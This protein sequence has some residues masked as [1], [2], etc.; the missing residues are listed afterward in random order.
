[1]QEKKDT[2]ISYRLA[3]GEWFAYCIYS[4]LIAAGYSV[5][6]DVVSLRGGIFE[7][8]IME[9]VQVCKD[10][11]LILPPN[12]LDRCAKAEM[13]VLRH[14]FFVSD[15][16]MKADVFIRTGKKHWAF[17]FLGGD[18]SGIESYDRIVMAW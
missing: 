5:F 17:C 2:F 9:Q 4:E 15:M 3:G 7:Q 1:M 13:M 10:F 16:G 8:D 12:V 11:I 18:A 6:F 14:A